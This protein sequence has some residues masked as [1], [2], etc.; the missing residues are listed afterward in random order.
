VM[1]GRRPAPVRAIRDWARRLGLCAEEAALIAAA[2]H[3]ELR[4]W[5]AEG[6]AIVSGRAHWEILRLVHS[7]SFRADTRWIAGEARLTVDQVNEALSRLLRLG[8]LE[9]GEGGRWRDPTGAGSLSEAAFR[10]VALARV[11]E[12]TGEQPRG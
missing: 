6:W 2:S 7:E 4:P 3:H 8:L 12:R 9:M 5:T 10:G 1:R 11:R